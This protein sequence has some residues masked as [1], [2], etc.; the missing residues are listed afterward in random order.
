MCGFVG[1]TGNIESKNIEDYLKRIK[2]RGPDQT[3]SLF[4]SKKWTFGFNRLSILDLS[5]LGAQ[6]MQSRDKM[7]TIMHNGEIYNYL[8]LREDLEEKGYS[9]ASSGDTEVILN[10]YLEFGIDMLEKLQGMYALAIW[11]ERKQECYLV[12]DRYGIKPLYYTK[13]EK[14]FAFS[15]EVK[16]LLSMGIV[17]RQI[18]KEAVAEFLAFEY[19]HAP[20]TIFQSIKKLCPG[21]YLKLSTSGIE[22][23]EY[24]NLQEEVLKKVSE[25]DLSKE[26]NEDELQTDIQEEILGLLKES[27]RKHLRADVP[28]GVFLSGGFDSGIL[29][30]LASEELE[31][32]N[33]YTLNFKNGEF[34]ESELAR[35]LAEKYHTKH[36]E[37]QVQ[38]EDFKNLL[39]EILWYCDEPLGDSGILPN[40]IINKL[41]AEDGIKVVLS[42]AGG[43]ELFAGYSY[44][45]PND[46]EKKILKYPRI[47]KILS[48]F[49]KG[50]KPDL[51]AK[52]D[53]ALLYSV[54]PLKH[55][56]QLQ[57]GG[58]LQFIRDILGIDVDFM[59]LKERYVKDFQT[60]SLNKQLYLDFMTYLPDD[61]LLLADRTTMA[62]SVEGRLPFLYEPLVEKCFSLSGN[63]KAKNGK[64][65]ALLKEIARKYLPKSFYQA[66]KRGF[67]SPI[68]KW[69]NGEFGKLVY[70]VLNSE[71][72][73]KRD[74]WN[75]L[76][77]SDFVGNKLN[78]QKQFH[79]IYLLFVLELYF[80]IHL[81]ASYKSAQEI[82]ME[83]IYAG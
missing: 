5:P 13:A 33:T 28:V 73:R 39:P 65:K 61:L 54:N 27:V 26:K 7:V 62:H 71:K 1:F 81:D 14:E 32:I 77:Y 69:S 12:R 66:P 11:D 78:Y 68:Q 15:S 57:L 29:T 47:S 59:Y 46:K 42:G 72:A 58:N 43:D 40:Y 80:R 3:A 56:I 67:F 79:K 38:S 19:I 55:L 30:A 52:I 22:E 24:Y 83:E 44:Y 21:H 63:C 76:C 23:I 37:F 49:L 9:F 45:F 64:R 41:V 18:S 2:H 16:P 17:D 31:G 36:H 50:L 35:E 74:I 25:T 70:E 8:E 4:L 10:M 60:D 6:P 20:N 75:T 82:S 51:S 48:F 34:D 53:R